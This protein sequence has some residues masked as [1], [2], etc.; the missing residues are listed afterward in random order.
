MS[1]GFGIQKNIKDNFSINTGDLIITNYSNSLFET[2]ESIDLDI[3]DLSNLKNTTVKNLNKVAYN[4]VIYPT[5][6]S[7][8]ILVFKGYED[9]NNIKPHKL[10]INEV[11]VSEYFSK[12]SSLALSI[13]GS[14]GTGSL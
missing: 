4:P 8:D 10:K 1:I 3:I 14:K 6:S 13:I 5:D 9:L 7:F 11:S 12:S 2:G